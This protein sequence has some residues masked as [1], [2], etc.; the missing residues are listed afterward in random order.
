MAYLIIKNLH[1]YYFEIKIFL[2]LCATTSFLP[3]YKHINHLI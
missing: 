3:T 1:L 2:Y